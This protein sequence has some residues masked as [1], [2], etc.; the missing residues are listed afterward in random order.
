VTTATT[1]RPLD[2]AAVLAFAQKVFAHQAIAKGT[3]WPTWES[4]LD[5]GPHWPGPAR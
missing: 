5:C 3:A 4:A 1:E 2:E